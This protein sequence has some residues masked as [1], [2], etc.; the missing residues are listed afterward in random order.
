MVAVSLQLLGY[1][2]SV[3]ITKRE[4]VTPTRRATLASISHF[5]GK[6]RFILV[7]MAQGVHA[8]KIEEKGNI[9]GT[10]GSCVRMQVITL[11]PNA[12]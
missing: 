8:T 7:T 1:A 10:H 11:H 9:V 12:V 6:Q 5:L 3:T 4:A 2:Q